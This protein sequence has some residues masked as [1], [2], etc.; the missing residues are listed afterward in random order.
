MSIL[1]QIQSAVRSVLDS[2]FSSDM[3]VMSTEAKEIFSNPDDRKKYLEAVK[4]LSGSSHEEKI[5]LSTK[6]EI[7]LVS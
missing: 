3:D 2:Y 6:E 1:M 4:R 5:I 7:T